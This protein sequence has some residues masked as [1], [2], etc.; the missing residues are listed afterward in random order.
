MF[1]KLKEVESLGLKEIRMTTICMEDVGD[2][3]DEYQC[4][5]NLM[6]D[7]NDMMLQHV[8]LA[9][10]INYEVL[11]EDIFKYHDGVL[12]QDENFVNALYEL[13]KHI[14]FSLDYK[15]SEL[16]DLYPKVEMLMNI[17]DF[18]TKA[19]AYHEEISEIEE[20]SSQDDITLDEY[21]AAVEKA[22]FN[23]GCMVYHEKYFNYDK[24]NEC[25]DNN[26]EIFDEN[27]IAGFIKL[28]VQPSEENDKK[29]EDCVEAVENALKKLYTLQYN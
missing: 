7:M 5:I 20:K 24:F 8:C 22:Y 13:Q 1:L 10:G 19:N 16:E 26:A 28:Y 2:I 4:S 3:I 6:G 18:K 12:W 14:W 27:Y 15:Y 9:K 29:V 25:L 17:D 23:H 21:Y 11:K